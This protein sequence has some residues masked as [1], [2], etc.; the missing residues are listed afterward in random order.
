V[1]PSAA[2]APHA[3]EVIIR[4]AVEADMP[5]LQRVFR[6]AALSNAGD[7][8]ALLAHP[9]YLVFTGEWVAEGRTRVAIVVS[10]GRDHLTGFATLTRGRE[11]QPELEDLFVDPECRRRGIAR[12]LI[13]DAAS[14]AG[15]AGHQTITV[16]GNQHALDFYLAVGFVQIGQAE[17]ELGPAPRLRLDLT[18]RHHL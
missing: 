1:T 6:A 2:Q 13:Q 14:L 9:E 4:S 17:T 16:T 3:D 18:D 5:E 10:D 7:A 8:P 15:R 12:R 11:G